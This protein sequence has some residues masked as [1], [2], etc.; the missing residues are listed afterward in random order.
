MNGD[1][2]GGWLLREGKR[3]LRSVCPQPLLNWREA[4]YYGKYGEV[5]LH[6][7]EY[8]CA[9]GRDSIDVG[10]NEG[11]YI[12][13]LKRYSRCVYAFEPIPELAQVLARKFRH[14]VIVNNIALSDAVG[15]AVLRMPVVDGVVVTG[16]STIAPQASL[17]YTEHREIRV[18]MQP[19]DQIYSGN[20]GFMK[21]DV[22]G[23][24]GAVL[25]GA[26]RTLARCHPKLLIEIDERLSPGGISRISHL[27]GDMDYRGFFI[28]RRELLPIGQFDPQ[29]MQ[30]PEDIPDLTAGLK[31]R[32]RFGR[33]VYNFLF[34]PMSEPHETLRNIRERIAQL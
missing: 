14:G 21:I 3:T 1:I 6:I 33:Y 8:L 4:Q 19:L 20:A 5:E 22:E 34:F 16:C 2:S 25:E 10:A 15:T 29:S 28:F 13:Y 27:L 23:H 12:H 17:A 30:R 31:A 18:P 26:R 9:R 11:S 24:E 7:L 32:E